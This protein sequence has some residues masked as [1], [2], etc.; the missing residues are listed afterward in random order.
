MEEEAK[1]KEVWERRAE[2]V[3]TD[4]ML[5]EKDRWLREKEREMERLEEEKEKRRMEQN[6]GK[7]TWTQSWAAKAREVT[8]PDAGEVPGSGEAKPPT[9]SSE[10]LK[11]V[12]DKKRRKDKK[13]QQRPA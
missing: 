1:K 7:T 13:P 3:G 5:V 2:L 12:R 10:G 6:S 8:R 4:R 11:L 9:E